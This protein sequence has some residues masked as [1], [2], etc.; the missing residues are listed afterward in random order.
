MKEYWRNRLHPDARTCYARLLAGFGRKT[1]GALDCGN[2]SVAAIQEAYFAIYNDHPELFYLGHAPRVSQR[3]S[4]FSPF[5]L[6]VSSSVSFDPVYSDGEIRDCEDKIQRILSVLQKQ[7]PPQAADFEKVIAAAEYIV[8]NTTYAI[9]DQMN[10]NAAAALCYGTAQCSGIAKAFKL[11]M[12][13]FSVFCIVVGGDADDGKGNRGPHAWNIVGID[14]AYYHVDV[15]FMLGANAQKKE[16]L[17]RIYLFYDDA[18]CAGDHKWDRTTVPVCRDGGRALHELAPSGDGR[19]DTAASRRR[20][21]PAGCR[22][23]SSLSALRQAMGEMIE[24]KRSEQDFY[25]EVGLKTQNE[26]AG[27]VRNAF[28]MTAAR[29]PISCG[30]TVTVAGDLLVHIEIT[31]R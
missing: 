29:Y 20:Q 27:A 8:K 16:P 23:Y 5:A 9:N 1:A 14:G 21:E 18:L 17:R 22:H 19:R 10:Q 3:K 25:L 24:N 2:A 26:V 12:D 4:G 11:L 13:A 6:T 31:Y 28:R 7:L 30:L 15:T